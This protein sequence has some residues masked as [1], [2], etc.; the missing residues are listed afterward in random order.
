ME[1]IAG[2]V[3]VNFPLYIKS[4]LCQRGAIMVKFNTHTHTA[5]PRPVKTPYLLLPVRP[6]SASVCTL[7]AAPW[8]DWRTD[9]KGLWEA[10]CRGRV[11]SRT[12][13]SYRSESEC[14][15]CDLPAIKRGQ[16]MFHSS[17]WLFIVDFVFF[18]WFKLVTIFC[19]WGRNSAGTLI[20]VP[21]AL[22]LLWLVDWNRFRGE[23]SGKV[24]IEN[25]IISSLD[26]K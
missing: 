4:S 15:T 13:S 20:L 1:W 2:I 26:S 18:P 5:Q 19:F 14:V 16:E 8:S 12:V 25:K 10:L 24:L 6:V 21:A 3:A 22:L 9:T 23:V 7:S 11:V 17:V